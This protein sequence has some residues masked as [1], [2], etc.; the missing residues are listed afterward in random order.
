MYQSRK[1]MNSRT[2]VARYRQ[3]NARPRM[4]RM[5]IKFY[6]LLWL[7]EYVQSFGA[8]LRLW[9]FCHILVVAPGAPW[10]QECCNADRVE[11]HEALTD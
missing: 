5:T 1:I 6:G 7:Q 9:L 10:L 4:P 3:K 8:Q 11:E 2:E